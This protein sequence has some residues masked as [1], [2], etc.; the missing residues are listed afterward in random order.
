MLKVV[1]LL[2]YQFFRG[3]NDSVHLVQMISGVIRCRYG[4]IYG[5]Q[6]SQNCYHSSRSRCQGRT[7]FH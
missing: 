7:F 3:A 1:N 6:W 2:I 5:V 4:W